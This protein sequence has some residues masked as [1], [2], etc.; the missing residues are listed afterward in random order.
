[1]PIKATGGV[2]MS[3]EVLSGFALL[4]LLDVS[5]EEWVKERQ[6]ARPDVESVPVSLVVT[7]EEEWLA[8]DREI[9]NE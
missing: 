2:A 9:G 4:A 7:T 6:G 5:R 3:E 8:Y 1:M